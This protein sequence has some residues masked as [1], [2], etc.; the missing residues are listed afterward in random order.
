[1]LYLQEQV[2]T[3]LAILL[4]LPLRIFSFLLAQNISHWIGIGLVL[5]ILLRRHGGMD[6]TAAL[7]TA[8]VR[9]MQAMSAQSAESQS[10]E[11]P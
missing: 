3:L 6:S 10:K 2:T 4:K 8:S 5:R 11:Q 9:A 7:R 1:M